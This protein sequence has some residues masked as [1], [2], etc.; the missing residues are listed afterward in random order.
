MPNSHFHALGAAQRRR[1]GNWRKLIFDS[2]QLIERVYVIFHLDTSSNIRLQIDENPV[3]AFVHIFH[4]GLDFL[5][6]AFFPYLL[7]ASSFLPDSSI[8]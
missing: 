2:Y 1:T 4:F 6:L 5:A 7:L 3:N 8:F